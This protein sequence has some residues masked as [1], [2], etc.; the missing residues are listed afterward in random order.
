MELTA[1][2]FYTPLRTYHTSSGI[3]C[4]SDPLSAGEPIFYYYDQTASFR[5]PGQP[6]GKVALDAIGEWLV[7]K[8]YELPI[9]FGEVDPP[10]H[11]AIKIKREV[12]SLRP[13]NT[14]RRGHPRLSFQYKDTFGSFNR[15]M[16]SAYRAL[17]L[18]EAI[19]SDLST[20]LD[21]LGQLDD[22]GKL[23][24]RQKAIYYEVKSR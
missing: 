3:T 4:Q 5:P 9:G 2:K 10:K 8:G 21:L 1:N 22:A 15:A 23:T 13:P 14:L 18:H 7:D 19:M 17:K 24:D 6:R 11:R 20:T 12:I 16:H